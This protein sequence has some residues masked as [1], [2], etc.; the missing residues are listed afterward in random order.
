MIPS[1]LTVVQVIHFWGFTFRHK[2][3]RVDCHS[4]SENMDIS[5]NISFKPKV[6]TTTIAGLGRQTKKVATPEV[7]SEFLGAH[8][9]SL[10]F[11]TYNN[12]LSGKK[13]N[14]KYPFHTC[15]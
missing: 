7:M 8:F 13:P 10:I 2:Y 15:K 5:K 3:F 1:P 4:I 9:R 14:S 6:K 11:S 12:N